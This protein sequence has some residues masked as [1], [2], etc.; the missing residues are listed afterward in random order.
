M[1][2]SLFKRIVGV[3]ILVL[4]GYSVSVLVRALNM[5]DLQNVFTSELNETDPQRHYYF[6]FDHSPKGQAIT[7]DSAN[8]FVM[9]Y[10]KAAMLG[11]RSAKAYNP[12]VIAHHSMRS[13][14][15]YVAGDK[16][17]LPIFIDNANWLVDNQ[18]GEGTWQI[19]HV[20][21]KGTGK[22]EPPWISGLSQGLGISVLTKAFLETKDSVY[23][24][25]AERAL[26]PFTKT[27]EN[28][29]L[30]FERE[31]TFSFEEYPMGEYSP[32]VLN[33]HLYALFGL[34]D[35]NDFT[36]D[37]MVDSL[38]TIGED[39]MFQ[40]VNAFDADF[41]SY[42]SMQRNRKFSNHYHLSSPWYQ[43][44]HVAQMKALYRET[45]IEEF[46]IMA[47]KFENQLGN[48]VRLVFNLAYVTYVDL[49]LLIRKLG[50]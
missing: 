8:I 23:L 3:I 42:Y 19:H 4:I 18:T 17:Q 25:V 45:G 33:G 15:K 20:V 22:T 10:A 6:T 16:G 28:D 38:I 32:G 50:Y 34:Y 14:Q 44:L 48:P 24:Q 30:L 37:S 7:R 47:D 2:R 21:T 13:W 40:H 27:L 41:W 39:F 36:E 1:S 49:V 29:G 43:M 9:D 46:R 12:I 26:K 31:G 11:V 35:L 5:Y